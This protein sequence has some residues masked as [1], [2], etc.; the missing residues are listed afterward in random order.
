MEEQKM[1]RWLDDR[2][3]VCNERVNSWDKRLSKASGYK[4]ILC[5]RCIAKEYDIT[6]DELRETAEHHFGLTPCFGI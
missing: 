5:E 3:P 1:V 6:V 4:Q 2:C